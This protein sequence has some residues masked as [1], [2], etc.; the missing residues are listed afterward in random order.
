MQAR[1]GQAPTDS[2]QSR[3]E[4]SDDSSAELGLHKVS[5]TQ[6]HDHWEDPLNML[7]SLTVTEPLRTDQS[8]CPHTGQVCTEGDSSA[9]QPSVLYATGHDI[10]RSPTRCARNHENLGDSSLNHSN[11]EYF[12]NSPKAGRLDSLIS[13]VMEG[14]G[15]NSYSPDMFGLYSHYKGV[16]NNLFTRENIQVNCRS[17]K[18]IL[19]HFSKISNRGSLYM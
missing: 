16:L 8:T 19:H 15:L 13:R 9:P 10:S 5:P 12:P 14:T 4:C 2:P 1:C 18:K 11:S 3:W 7:L 6:W 17:R